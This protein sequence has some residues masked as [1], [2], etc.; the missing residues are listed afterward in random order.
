[1]AATFPGV[2]ESTCFSA[3]TILR[4]QGLSRTQY[5]EAYVPAAVETLLVPTLLAVTWTRPR[6]TL[7][8]LATEILLSVGLSSWD[9]AVHLSPPS[10]DN[11]QTSDTALAITSALPL[12]FL[13]IFTTSHL[14][15]DLRPLLPPSLRSKPATHAFILLIAPLVPVGFIGALLPSFLLLVYARRL[16]GVETIGFATRSDAR[17]HD[18]LTWAGAGASALYVLCT[19]ALA[20]AVLS[21][22]RVR[23]AR[24]STRA[25]RWRAAGVVAGLTL[26]AAEMAMAAA[27][28]GFAVILA[29]RVGR[30]VAR[31]VL[32]LGLLGM[33]RG[34]RTGWDELESPGRDPARGVKAARDNWRG[35]VSSFGTPPPGRVPLGYPNPPFIQSPPDEKKT[36]TKREKSKKGKAPPARLQIGGPVEG[37]FRKLD[38]GATRDFYALHSAKLGGA[39]ME[40]GMGSA[41]AGMGAAGMVGATGRIPMERVVFRTPAARAPILSFTSSTFDS[42]A[43]ETLTRTVRPSPSPFSPSS[44]GFAS[45]SSNPFAEPR[46]CRT[47]FSTSTTTVKKNTGSIYAPSRVSVEESQLSRWPP[48]ELLPGG[49]RSGSAAGG[50]V[51]RGVS[52]QPASGLPGAVAPGRG[53]SPNAGAQELGE[54]LAA[55]VPEDITS[56]EVREAS[57]LGGSEVGMAMGEE[58]IPGVGVGVKLRETPRYLTGNALTP[59][60]TPSASPAPPA[61]LL[62]ST[63]TP[64]GYPLPRTNSIKRKPPPELE[65]EPLPVKQWFTSKAANRASVMASV[66]WGHTRHGSGGSGVSGASG[67]SIGTSGAG[68][69]A[70]SGMSSSTVRTGGPRPPPGNAEWQPRADDDGWGAQGR[71]WRPRPPLAARRSTDPSKMIEPGAFSPLSPPTPQP[72]SSFGGSGAPQ[73]RWHERGES[74]GGR[75]ASPVSAY[76][77]AVLSP[78]HQQ[79]L[80]FAT[81][82]ETPSNSPPKD[83]ILSSASGASP[84]D[85]VMPMTMGGGIKGTPS[86]PRIRQSQVRSVMESLSRLQRDAGL[87]GDLDLERLGSVAE[88]EDD[89]EGD[90]RYLAGAGGIRA[91]ELGGA[92]GDVEGDIGMDGGGVG[93]P[94]PDGW[95]M[96]LS[97]VWSEGQTPRTGS[98][99]SF[100][101]GAQRR[102]WGTAV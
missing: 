52:P 98:F 27:P 58:V 61:A 35:T 43:L 2:T 75:S 101:L 86:D 19:A 68:G 25:S 32:V 21:R 85:M 69:S 93:R 46:T 77:T 100:P 50:A 67:R 62:P 96:S 1:M 80:F 44:P 51:G 63:K 18:V 9:L 56:A 22:P 82:T 65:D 92:R 64:L 91:G 55:D 83:D 48:V 66:V 38:T 8:F 28:Q 40:A 16:D 4:C 47:A 6:S 13:L 78:G 14:L 73:G 79:G 33:Y 42:S 24:T 72:P 10:A 95:R 71:S 102:N 37:T 7:I 36:K 41:L 74:G 89:D 97:T 17:L 87:D 90:G 76:S 3:V 45:P 60:G 84:T 26:A 53:S 99:R 70:L 81:P 49:S 20:S 5:I 59:S 31:G 15:S 39:G 12:L 30:C 57:D 54:H 34:Q 29:R 88:S 11:F 23:N 94:G